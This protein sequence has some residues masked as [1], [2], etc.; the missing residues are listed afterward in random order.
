MKRTR[1]GSHVFAS[2]RTP[3]QPSQSLE[4]LG[5]GRLATE[6]LARVSHSLNEKA[7]SEYTTSQ[8]RSRSHQGRRINRHTQPL[9]S[10][11]NIVLERNHNS[12]SRHSMAKR[13][14]A[15]NLNEDFSENTHNAVD[16][17]PSTTLKDSPKK[18]R[19]KALLQAIDDDKMSIATDLVRCGKD[20]PTRY[21]ASAEKHSEGS[22]KS[23]STG[24]GRLSRCTPTAQR[25][26][27]PSDFIKVAEQKPNCI[28]R[29]TK[30]DPILRHNATSAQLPSKRTYR[31]ERQCNRVDPILLRLLDDDHSP[32]E[33]IT[34]TVGTAVNS[35]DSFGDDS[36]Y[37]DA[38]SSSSYGDIDID[39]SLLEDVCKGYDT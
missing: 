29:P 1:S 7:I 10:R 4:L 26:L 33:S 39:A 3:Q 23:E 21:V 22:S 12:P 6:M 13:T 36:L 32:S 24:I 9:Q 5:N 38:N 15:H 14:F 16:A 11:S 8:Q 17:K 25:T 35:L 19:L 27:P 18:G 31:V 20:P 2:N 30:L 28:V 37:N 34:S